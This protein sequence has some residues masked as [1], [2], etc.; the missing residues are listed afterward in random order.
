MSAMYFFFNDVQVDTMPF[1]RNSQTF[2]VSSS[3]RENLLSAFQSAPAYQSDSAAT[4]TKPLL[5]DHSSH[6]AKMMEIDSVLP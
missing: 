1:Q 6:Q 4:R 5:E 2:V 3:P